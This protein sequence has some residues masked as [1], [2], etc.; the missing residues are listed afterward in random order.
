MAI[1][2]A[3][4]F[5]V[6]MFENDDFLTTIIEKRSYTRGENTTGDA[7]CQRIVEIANE[8]GFR[9]NA[10]EFKSACNNYMSDFD[11]WGTVQKIFHIFRVVNKKYKM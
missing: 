11:G 8:M 6:R 9:F 5:L 1:E 2:H 3:N 7:E 4:S 10:D